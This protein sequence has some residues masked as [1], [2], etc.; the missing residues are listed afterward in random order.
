MKEGWKER[1]KKIV[2]LSTFSRRNG[3]DD[4]KSQVRVHCPR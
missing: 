2:F 1:K 3:D 4:R